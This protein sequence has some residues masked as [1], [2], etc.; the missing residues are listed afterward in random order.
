MTNPQLRKELELTLDLYTRAIQ[1]HYG[2]RTVG[3]VLGFDEAIERIEALVTLQADKAVQDALLA[4]RH[5]IEKTPIEMS[6]GRT[7]Q[8]LDKKLAELK[9]GSDE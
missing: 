1:R 2:G 5:E 6:W 7:F 4:V 3:K 9:G 8:Y